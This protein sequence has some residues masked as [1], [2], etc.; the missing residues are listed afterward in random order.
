MELLEKLE[1]VHRKFISISDEL[2]DPSA[3]L[4]QVKFT[5][6]SKER[7]LLLSVDEVYHRYSRLLRELQGA[8]E[9]LVETRDPELRA[10]TEEELRELETKFAALTDEI[11]VLLIPADPNDSRN[12]IIE[13]R[14]GTGD[15]HPI[16]GATRLEDRTDRL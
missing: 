1:Q 3:S 14:A 5:T 6:L 13:V 11:K 2:E 9:L 10:M 4:D 15:V 16:C 7:H 12:S 8:R